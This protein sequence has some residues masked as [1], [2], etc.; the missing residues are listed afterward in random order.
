MSNR[1]WRETKQYRSRAS[2]G[3]QISC[4]LVSLQLYLFLSKAMSFYHTAS[5]RSPS[6]Q[7]VDQAT[8]WSVTKLR[9]NLSEHP[10][11]RSALRPSRRRSQRSPAAATLLFLGS[12]EREGSA[13]LKRRGFSHEGETDQ[14]DLSPRAA[15]LIIDPPISDAATEFGAC[16]P[17][18]GEGERER[19]FLVAP[20]A[21]NI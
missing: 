1:K 3:H 2:S 16:R 20:S 11:S 18:K 8:E 12:R 5:A 21:F 4:C 19:A 6:S 10:Q 17:R 14:T 15:P 7:F 13:R 9:S